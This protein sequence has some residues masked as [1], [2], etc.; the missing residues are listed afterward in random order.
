MWSE[1]YR[2]FDEDLIDRV[3]FNPTVV[4]IE[5]VTVWNEV[6]WPAIVFRGKA[7]SRLVAQT[8]WFRVVVSVIAPDELVVFE[9]PVPIAV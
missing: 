8:V 5:S 1:L 4:L 6:D 7:M 2:E 3:E 9:G